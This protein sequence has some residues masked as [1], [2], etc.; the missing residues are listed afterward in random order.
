M[1]TPIYSSINPLRN[2]LDS[3]ISRTLLC[4]IISCSA[5]TPQAH[6]AIFADNEARTAILDLRARYENMQRENQAL[7][8]SIQNLEDQ[9]DTL[10]KDMTQH[11]S[12]ETQLQRDVT[13][14]RE[15]LDG[16]NTTSNP[17]DTNTH[18]A[19]SGGSLTSAAESKNL[20]AVLAH[21]R[22]NDYTSARTELR[23]YLAESP[24]PEQRISALY[25]LGNAEYGLRNHHNAI[26]HYR[27]VITQAPNHAHTPQ[28]MLALASCQLELQDTPAAKATLTQL[29]KKYPNTKAARIAKTRIARLP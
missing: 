3:S 27:N 23:Q 29:I 2:L 14:L 24:T 28:A 5:L 11:R 1:T 22:N 16:I 26:L 4:G 15:T 10:R 19:L 13:S 25:W 8:T 6:A 18:E 7:R 12:R 21:F 9:I 17:S 20:D